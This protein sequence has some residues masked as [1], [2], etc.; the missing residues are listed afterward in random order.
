MTL[1]ADLLD[2][3]AAL[4]TATLSDALDNCGLPPGQGGLTPIWGRPRIAGFAA[5]AELERLV[6][7]HGGAHILTELTAAAGPEDILVIA[8]GG[9]TDV[10]SW[11]GILSVGASMRAIRGVVTD[12]ACRD[13]SQARE[14]GFPVYAR[15]QV[16]VTARGRLRQRSAGAPI[17]FGEVTVE[18]G[19][20]VVADEGGVV[21]V[22]HAHAAEV[23]A[24]AR[25]LHAREEQILG[26]VRAG[27]ALPQA[28]HDARLAGR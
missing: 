8:T 19:D 4:D 11:G 28:M 6:G 23:L 7:E 10:S 12:G 5:T 9:R 2:Q 3:F 17:R 18:P 26:E 13:V 25:R 27:T 24:E 15:A 20:V 22:P 1:T 14:L 21:I 16:P